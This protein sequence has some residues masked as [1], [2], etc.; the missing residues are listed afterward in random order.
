MRSQ[1]PWLLQQQQ[2]LQQS[3]QRLLVPLLLLLLLL[4]GIQ[5]Q[6]QQQQQLLQQLLLLL[7]C[8]REQL[9]SGP[10][11]LLC[12]TLN[13]LETSRADED[14]ETSSSSSSSSSKCC[15]SHVRWIV[16]VL[17]GVYKAIQLGEQQTV[18]G[19]AWVEVLQSHAI[20]L[21][22]E[23]VLVPLEVAGEDAEPALDVV[24]REL[25][26][27]SENQKYSWPMRINAMGLARACR[28]S[29]SSSSSSSSRRLQEQLQQQLVLHFPSSVLPD[30]PALTLCCLHLQRLAGLPAEVPVPPSEL[31]PKVLQQQQE[32]LQQNSGKLTCT[33]RLSLL[34][35]LRTAAQL[36][37]PLLL[38]EGLAAA[39]FT[40]FWRLV[41]SVDEAL[42][43][44]VI[45]AANAATHSRST[46]LYPAAAAVGAQTRGGP[47]SEDS[48]EAAETAAAA[49]AA[50]AAAEEPSMGLHACLLL[51]TLFYELVCQYGPAILA[52]PPAAPPDECVLAAA[53]AV[54]QQLPQQVVLLLR[55]YVSMQ[56]QRIATATAANQ[57]SL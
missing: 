34:R 7:C 39:S 18:T 22:E 42:W 25:V 17:L 21:Q 26:A 20:D 49:A 27:V 47:Q 10:A 2:Q 15:C 16:L 14:T 43:L 40:G 28:P 9:R 33:S 13:E 19:A 48:A 53:A 11:F 46:C 8:C 41:F 4:R 38:S 12:R 57:E 44:A 1:Q 55:H 6:Q 50:S 35:L 32:L 45:K 30:D 3:T 52:L 51:R 31:L 24:H 37:P 23:D 36:L 29:S 56:Q 5:Q 54:Q